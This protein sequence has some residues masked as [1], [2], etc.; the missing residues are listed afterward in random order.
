[1][2]KATQKTIDGAAWKLVK[3]VDNAAIDATA[4]SLDALSAATEEWFA[5]ERE[6][7]RITVEVNVSVNYDAADM[8]DAAERLRREAK[9]RRAESDAYNEAVMDKMAEVEKIHPEIA[10]TIQAITPYATGEIE[11]TNPVEYMHGPILRSFAPEVTDAN[12]K[13]I[14]D[15]KPVRRAPP[16]C[17]VIRKTAYTHTGAI[18]RFVEARA[19]HEAACRKLAE[20]M[21]AY[22][23]HMTP[24]LLEANKEQKSVE[25]AVALQS[26]RDAV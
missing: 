17:A 23:D 10:G 11:I 6:L 4:E 2:Q 1:M 25:A 19:R 13:A 22:I 14:K 3:P 9:K 20:A 16:D 12:A 5:A 24:L 7:H 8:R 26:K 21:K 18:F 15:F